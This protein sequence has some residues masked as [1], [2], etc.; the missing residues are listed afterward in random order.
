MSRPW[1]GRRAAREGVARLLRA[2]SR[3]R[4]GR[5]PFVGAPRSVVILVPRG[6]GDAILLTPLLRLLRLRF[7]AVEIHVL[8]FSAALQGFFRDD[9]NVTAVHSPGDGRLRYASRLLRRRFD[10]LYNPKDRPSRTFLLHGALLRPGFS[11]GH[12]VSLHDGLF[13][14]L[15][16]VDYDTNM[17]LK[18]CA[19]MK[20]FGQSP[21]PDDCRPYVPPMPVSPAVTA[22]ASATQA[23]SL[24]GLNISARKPDRLWTSA[25]WSALIRRFAS[26]RFTVFSAPEDV[27]LRRAIEAS[28]TNVVVSPPTGNLCEVSVMVARLRLLVSPDTSLVH[29]ASA[30]GTPVVG[31]YNN[32]RGNQTRFGPFLVPHEIVA[33]P[34]TR[35]SDIS[36]DSVADAVRRLLAQ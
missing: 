20:A 30:T 31:L 9:P 3:P 10:V 19:A 8:V 29:V 36:V 34:T 14:Y 32:E 26:H 22:W 21:A 27:G 15:L 35:V 4:D 2:F 7:P 5:T 1:K 17:A 24:I 23:G 28:G 25:C 18:N 33:S 6:L 12:E 11:I 16:Q 13:D